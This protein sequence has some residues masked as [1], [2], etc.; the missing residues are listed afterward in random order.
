MYVSDVPIDMVGN[1]AEAGHRTVAGLDMLIHQAAHQ[2]SLLGGSPP[3]LARM[4]AVGRAQLRGPRPRSPTPR[5]TTWRRYPSVIPARV[6]PSS[7]TRAISSLPMGGV[8][9][10]AWAES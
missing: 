1:W 5:V 8:S 10:M 4:T 6:I 7:V 2:V 3:D 9:Q